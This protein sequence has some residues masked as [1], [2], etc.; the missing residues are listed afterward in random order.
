MRGSEWGGRRRE[1]GRNG[2][3]ERDG[4]G[5]ERRKGGRG[6]GSDPEDEAEISGEAAM[7]GKR[8]VTVKVGS[9]D[10]GIGSN[11]RSLSLLGARVQEQGALASEYKRDEPS[12]EDLES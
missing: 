5:G 4:R 11:R 6:C 7:E 8:A 1:M 9:G 2:T 3:E 10:E 12:H